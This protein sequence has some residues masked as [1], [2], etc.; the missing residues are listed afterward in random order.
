MAYYN[1]LK[2]EVIKDLKPSAWMVWPPDEHNKVSVHVLSADGE[3]SCTILALKPHP[4]CT[5]S[6][7]V[8]FTIFG[9]SLFRATN[10]GVV[11]VPSE[12]S[13]SSIPHCLEWYRL[14]RRTCLTTTYC[15]SQSSK[16][17]YKLP[18]KFYPFCCSLAGACM[19]CDKKIAIK[20]PTSFLATL[21]LF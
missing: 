4:A 12:C 8:F 14:V 15:S 10:D 20:K 5:D 1:G 11:Y 7:T 13:L 3:E 9:R 6:G 16:W 2:L 17:S 19:Y 21:Q 18:G